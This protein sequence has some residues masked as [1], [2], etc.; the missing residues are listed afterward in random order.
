MTSGRDCQVLKRELDAFDPRFGVSVSTLKR[1]WFGSIGWG[2]QPIDAQCVCQVLRTQVLHRLE[3]AVG[4][5]GGVTSAKVP[6][7]TPRKPMPDIH[8]RASSTAVVLR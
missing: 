2:I 1:F 7:P 3:G 6:I 5:E 4:Q 8:P